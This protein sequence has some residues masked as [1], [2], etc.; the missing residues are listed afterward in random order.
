MKKLWILVYLV[1]LG[2]PFAAHAAQIY[3]RDTI[4]REEISVQDAEAVTSLVRDAVVSSGQD[5]LVSNEW[6]AEY[7]LQPRVLKLGDSYI[8]TVERKRGDDVIAANQEKAVTYDDLNR[9][10]SR[11]TIAALGHAPE[12]VA[13]NAAPAATT[14]ASASPVIAPS[15]GV[16]RMPRSGY[17]LS[18]AGKTK[19]YWT[20]G[21][22]PAIGRRLE[23]DDIF[24]SLSASHQWDV[25]PRASVKA[26]A[27]T[28]V[29]TGGE[30][31]HLYNFGA[32]ANWYFM[33]TMTGA[34]YITGDMGFGF[35]QN[36]LD[37]KSDGFT[38]GAGAGYQFFRTEKTSMDVLIRYVVLTK[39]VGDEDG[40]PQV[41]GARVAVNF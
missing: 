34:A 13:A 23:S 19:H 26:L 41:L 4:A 39:E 1:V 10:A 32:G 16:S 40:L 3:V 24:Y 17:Q 28:S 18:P 25:H 14:P 6:E 33:P 8:L 21:L 9:A 37:N 29:S 30:S 15:G 11:A 5:R 35:A 7:S 36:S 27:E 38:F 22:G 12:N 20:V 2:L 31:A